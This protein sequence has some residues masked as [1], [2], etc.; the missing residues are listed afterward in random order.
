MLFRQVEIPAC[1][2]RSRPRAGK[3]GPMQMHR[4]RPSCMPWRRLRPMASTAGAALHPSWA[5]GAFKG[6]KRGLGGMDVVMGSWRAGR[7]PR[8][9]TGPVGL[10]EGHQ[11]V[12]AAA[13]KAEGVAFN[14]PRCPHFG[15]VPLPHSASTRQSTWHF[16]GTAK[17]SAKA[18]SLPSPAVPSRPFDT[19][20]P[21]LS[22]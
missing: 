3:L 8:A 11:A 4:H 15:W 20:A 6:R 9:L 16:A 12:G 13:R 14:C 7:A 22:P 1:P 21:G 18:Q 5:S 2:R 19:L 17:A 10:L